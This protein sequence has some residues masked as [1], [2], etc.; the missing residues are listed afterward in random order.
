MARII[1][2]NLFGWQEIDAASDLDR[3]RMALWGLPDEGLVSHLERLRGRGRN[4]YPV[5][6]MWNALVA[7]VVFQHVSSASL[8]RELRRNAELRQLCGFDPYRGEKAVPSEDAFGRFL[9]N[10]VKAQEAIDSMFHLLVER[11]RDELPS[12]GERLAIDSKAISSHGRTVTDPLKKVTP[13][14]RRDLDADWGRK[15]YKGVHKDGKPW[16][17]MV[18]WFGYKLHLVVDALYELPLA[19]KVTKAS[20][21]DTTELEPLLE[22]MEEHHPAVM[23]QASTLVADKGYDSGSNNISTYDRFHIIPIIDKRNGLWKDGEKTKLI[24]P[25]KSESFVYDEQ[26]NVFCVCP[27]SGDHKNMMFMGFES[28]RNT[29]KYRCP[30]AGL[31]VDCQGRSL[32]EAASRTSSFGRVLRVPL[33]TD[34]RIFTPIARHSQR[35]KLHYNT[36]SS[37]ERVN[38]RIDQVFGFERH[39]LRGQAKMEMRVCLA[40]VVLLS[41]ALGRIRANQAHLMRSL[42]A[43]APRAA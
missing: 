4:D 35:W 14:G 39:F 18:K 11:L 3:L 19:Y 1:N 42:T 17:K 26:G 22:Q 38:S 23:K 9:A 25:S 27:L 10:V 31:G 13:D 16:E 33:E 21:S 30:A 37:V 7:G 34:R 8:I 2:R 28:D 41:M 32:C 43:P 40:L 24:D 5:R 12:L 6:A 20:A 36:R 29:L 15:T